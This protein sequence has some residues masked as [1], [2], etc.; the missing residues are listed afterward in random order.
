MVD[1]IWCRYENIP[2][3]LECKVFSMNDVLNS[4]QNDYPAFQ[5]EN[6]SH[7]SIILV[8]LKSGEGLLEELNSKIN[9][10]GAHE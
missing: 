10:G 1:Y 4:V 7:H 8:N 9:D 6:F 3:V 2:N 5:L